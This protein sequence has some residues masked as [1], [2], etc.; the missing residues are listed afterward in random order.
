M[1]PDFTRLSP[2]ELRVLKLVEKRP[3][4]GRHAARNA[5]HH[6]ERAL[7]IKDLDPEMAAFRAITGEEEASRAVIHALQRLRYPGAERLSHKQHRHKAAIV[8][9]L[10]AVGVLINKGPLKAPELQVIGNDGEDFIRLAFEVSG[11]DGGSIR[12]YPNPPLHLVLSLNDHPPDFSDELNELLSATNLTTVDK[13]IL[14]RAEERNH[15][16]YASE[17]GIPLVDPMRLGEAIAD[18]RTNVFGCIAAFLLIDSFP[19]HQN[20]VLQCLPVFLRLLAKSPRRDA[21]VPQ[22]DAGPTEN[23]PG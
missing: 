1:K 7:S 17:K 20:F 5:I 11:P 23:A 15:L 21:Q 8:P 3:S 13:W 6:I 16:L 18:R 12:V 2:L 19:V 14:S 22:P 10:A 4:P 9:F